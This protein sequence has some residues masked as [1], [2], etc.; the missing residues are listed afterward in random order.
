MKK[1]VLFLIFLSLFSLF[2]CSFSS[3]S[4]V[5]N[6]VKQAYDYLHPDSRNTI[7]NWKNA[8]KEDFTPNRD[9]L[10]FN[11]E[12]NKSINIKDKKTF[13]VTFHTNEDAVL[14]PIE[15]F[16]DKNTKETLGVALRD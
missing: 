10:V 9:F 2:G 12:K 3:D 15:V 1:F 7:K 8:T 4:N 11:K 16:I 5:S 6:D 14:G 13:K